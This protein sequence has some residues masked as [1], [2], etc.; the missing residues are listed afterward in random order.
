MISVDIDEEVKRYLRLLKRYDQKTAE[1]I[2]VNWLLAEIGWNN[3]Q[4][5]KLAKKYTKM[6]IRKAEDLTFKVTDEN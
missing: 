6:I 3:K 4:G 1:T 2:E 5:I